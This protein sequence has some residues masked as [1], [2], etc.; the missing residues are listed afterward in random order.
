MRMTEELEVCIVCRD[1]LTNSRITSRWPLCDWRLVRSPSDRQLTGLS[2]R[3]CDACGTVHFGPR[4]LVF[5]KPVKD[6]IVALA[7]L[8]EEP[9]TRRTPIFKDY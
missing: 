3:A 2:W 1:D 8:F 9:V 4:W 7:D 5:A 6:P